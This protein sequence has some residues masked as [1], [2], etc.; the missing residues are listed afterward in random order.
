MFLVTALMRSLIG[1]DQ[2]HYLSFGPIALQEKTTFPVDS[3]RVAH[4]L[5]EVHRLLRTFESNLSF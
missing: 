4:S 2:N 1:V 5:V 3:Q